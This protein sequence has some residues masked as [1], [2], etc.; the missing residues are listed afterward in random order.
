MQK[1]GVQILKI[2]LYDKSPNAHQKALRLVR[3]SIPY[4]K[5][6]A[7]GE[8]RPA[9]IMK[10]LA[11]PPKVG[12]RMVLL[13]HVL[14]Y[15]R[16]S[17]YL[18]IL[19]SLRDLPSGIAAWVVLRER[20]SEIYRW[21]FSNSSRL[22]GDKDLFAEDFAQALAQPLLS[23]IEGDHEARLRIGRDG[24]NPLGL[25]SVRGLPLFVAIRN[26]ARIFREKSG[27]F[28]KAVGLLCGAP[29]KLRDVPE[30][31][32]F[33]ET[34]FLVSAPLRVSGLT[35]DPV[36]KIQADAPSMMAARVLRAAFSKLVSRRLQPVGM[37]FQKVV[38]YP[39]IFATDPERIR[40]QYRP[41][42]VDFSSSIWMCLPTEPSVARALKDLLVTWPSF[43][44]Y[45]AITARPHSTQVLKVTEGCSLPFAWPEVVAALDIVQ[46]R[47]RR[48]RGRLEETERRW[49]STLR[50]CFAA[51]TPA[52]PSYAYVLVVPALI[53]SSNAERLAFQPPPP[54]MFVSLV[55][56]PTT[57]FTDKS[58]RQVL[59]DAAHDISSSLH[60]QLHRLSASR[61]ADAQEALTEQRNSLEDLRSQVEGTISSADDLAG[62]LLALVPAASA[63][64]ST[65][66]PRQVL[67]SPAAY[68]LFAPTG[69]LLR[70]PPVD[71]QHDLH[72]VEQ[73]DW[74]WLALLWLSGPAIPGN[75]K[76]SFQLASLGKR[77][78]SELRTSSAPWDV[79][80]SLVWACDSPTVFRICSDLIKN[81][82]GHNK[83]CSL[84]ALLVRLMLD[85]RVPRF[86]AVTAES[87]G[88]QREFTLGSPAEICEAYVK[89]F[90]S[91]R[92]NDAIPDIP[93]R[94]SAQ[95]IWMTAFC[96]FL[97]DS[98]FTACS[99]VSLV[100][101]GAQ[102]GSKF[103]F[104]AQV[105]ASH[106]SAETQAQVWRTLGDERH[107]GQ[108]AEAWRKVHRAVS[109]W[110]ATKQ[111]R[112]ADLVF[113]IDTYSGPRFAGDTRT[114]DFLWRLLHGGRKVTDT[115]LAR[116]FRYALDQTNLR[117]LDRRAHRLCRLP[118]NRLTRQALED[119]IRGLELLDT[120]ETNPQ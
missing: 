105:R 41:M 117:P 54:A 26:T 17:A 28:A 16:P 14:Y 33:S 27:H 113:R 80:R 112:G 120:E 45:P 75:I 34:H 68:T 64:V 100:L 23:S 85:L 29:R 71:A 4:S 110:R 106:R 13:S 114:V 55:L 82:H 84:F 52:S 44:S 59:D 67:D 19:D 89:R 115:R 57:D 3:G 5:V 108:L 60:A 78:L 62:R 99:R 92:G 48:F 7:A 70:W 86:A 51:A 76:T 119:I 50:H 53:M 79:L 77:E 22:G 63:V 94:E 109:P 46:Y 9:Q 36:V 90:V 98:Y 18:R 43:L 38:R 69:R 35:R 39:A 95:S 73:E 1:S 32:E 66:N 107:S 37:C 21:L 104:S 2:A 42:P 6:T 30:T 10:L 40:N 96:E 31:S 116:E 111:R 118:T 97:M 49:S 74:K 24:S 101:R 88:S 20:R 81:A 65:T 103:V 25:P 102:T 72:D 58:A 8:L 91:T 56:A 83:P 11:V 87:Q 61:L 93:P 47:P 15:M 12:F